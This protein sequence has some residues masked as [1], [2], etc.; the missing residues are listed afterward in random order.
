MSVVSGARVDDEHLFRHELPELDNEGYNQATKTDSANIACA[1]KNCLPSVVTTDLDEQVN[2]FDFGGSDTSGLNFELLVSLR[3]KHQRKQAETGVRKNFGHN[4]D[5]ATARQKLL[6]QFHQLIKQ[7]QERG[8]S[9]TLGRNIRWQPGRKPAESV[10]G[11]ALN[12]KE[13]ATR[14]AGQV[15]TSII[16]IA[17]ILLM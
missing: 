13:A 9:S 12:A 11:N 1:L 4:S 17:T 10:H 14:R 16:A 2:P 3:R 8:V 15:S 5:A 7:Q 6:Q